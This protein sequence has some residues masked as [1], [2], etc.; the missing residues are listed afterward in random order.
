MAEICEGMEWIT[1]DPLGIGELLCNAFKMTRLVLAGYFK[2]PRFLSTVLESAEKGLEAYSKSKSL[3]L[4]ADARLPFRELGM[5]I[6]LKGVEKLRTIFADNPVL[7]EK[8]LLSPRIA[9]L[10]KYAQLGEEIRGFWLKKENRETDAWVEHRDIN[11]VM[12][13]TSLAPDQ[14]LEI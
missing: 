5:S 7:R 2:H 3:E 1:D 8:Y 11:M 14:Y 6:G 9:G 4:P 13:A 12:L 10:L